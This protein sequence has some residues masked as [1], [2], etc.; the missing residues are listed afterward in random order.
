M[1]DYK[2][3]NLQLFIDI[4]T[5]HF[6]FQLYLI[7]CWHFFHAFVPF[8]NWKLQQ[9]LSI[10]L[11][12]ISLIYIIHGNP[13]FAD[14]CRFRAK[15]CLNVD[16]IL[17]KY[18]NIVNSNNSDTITPPHPATPKSSVISQFKPVVKKMSQ[19]W[20][21]TILCLLFY[22][23]RSWL[24]FYVSATFIH[25]LHIPWCPDV[26]NLSTSVLN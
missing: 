9:K 18:S 14:L 6:H 22:W 24:I 1:L 7:C 10:I 26:E 5:T 12:P 20:P 15:Q 13:V 11:Q 21:S 25:Y 16:N 4:I 3:Q 23:S 2:K 19:S 8:R 17:S